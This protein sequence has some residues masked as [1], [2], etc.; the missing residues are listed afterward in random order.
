MNPKEAKKP[1]PTKKA[2]E[3]VYQM[4]LWGNNNTNFYSGVGSHLPEIVNPY[5][6]ALRVFLTS[7]KE[8][9][10]L[11]DFGCG[12]F[13]VGK[14]LVKYTK[15]YI[16]VDIV[17]DL[18]KFNKERF[19]DEN[20]EFHCLDIATEILPSGDCAIIRQVLQHI[21]NAEIKSIA[22]KLRGFKYVILTEHIP[23]GD[24]TPNLDIISGQGIRLKKGSGVNVL[25]PP[26]NLKVEEETQL[27]SV[28][29][30]HG[31][32]VVVTTLYRLF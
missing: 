21:S 7:F 32:G 19:M 31:E 4:N 17:E 13:N 18:I 1:W 22:S 16:A 23:K 27:L 3:Q 8:P 5:I 14:E 2:M 20:L 30:A 24:F 12:D 15:K 29:L 28:K 25:E 11:C 6:D 10:V 9:I 26:F